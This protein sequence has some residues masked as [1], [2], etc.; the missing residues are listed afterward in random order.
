MSGTSSA[1]ADKMATAVSILNRAPQ[2]FVREAMILAKFTESEANSKSKQR[3]VCRALPGK[4]KGRMKEI[5]PL[6][7]VDLNAGVSEL[8]DLT[9]GTII[10]GNLS[11]SPPRKLKKQRLN[12]Q[13]VQY[14]REA[15]LY[16]KSRQSKAHK[17]ATLLYDQE[18]GKENGLSVRAVESEIKKKFNGLGP[19]A[20][21]IYRYVVEYGLVGML[22]RKP[23]P[24]GSISAVMDKSLCTA[25]GSF[26]RIN[27]INACGG[28]NS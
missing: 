10:N 23:G 15:D 6:S 11:P 14:K 18:R 12:S 4:S 27:Q 19:S 20:T 13:Q 5:L 21:T 26:M 16:K 3:K 17:A 7:S 22:P 24:E 2:L 1:D 28:N 8:S 25:F 9:T